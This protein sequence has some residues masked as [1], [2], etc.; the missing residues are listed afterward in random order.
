MAAALTVSG[1][2]CVATR[3]DIDQL[4]D[5]I[6]TV[7]AEGASAD[8]L[9]AVQL[10]QVL[11]AVREMNDTLASLALRIN[12]VRAESEGALR[13]VRRGIVQMQDVA[14][15]SQ[16]RLQEMRAA[17][18]ERS[19]A[20][21]VPGS[22]S[23]PGDTTQPRADS[24]VVDSGP[25]P[26][27]LF[28]VGRNQLTNGANASARSAFAEL[29]KRYPQSELAADAQF[30]IA[31]AYSAEGKGAAADSAYA[32]VLT[33][34]PSSARAPTAMYKRAIALQKA[35]RTTTARRMFNDLIKQFPESDEAELARERLRAMS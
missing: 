23:A 5:E 15:Q 18:E 22:P 33:N 4:R 17:L 1:T 35:G 27:Q 32:A 26:N 21:A 29:L 3:S 13:E 2:G 16:Q 20:R 9:R 10:V 6:N 12:R 7:R 11:R 30:Y 25:G 28:Q 31:E 24:A 34:Y 19:R 14:G 8:S